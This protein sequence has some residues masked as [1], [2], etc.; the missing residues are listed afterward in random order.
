M[1][2][3]TIS[4]VARSYG[5][6]ARMIR[7]YEQVG[8]IN[9]L[10]NEENSYRVYDDAALKR[11]R[12]IILLRKLQIPV[13]N[14]TVILNNPKKT[15]KRVNLLLKDITRNGNDGIGKPICMMAYSRIKTESPTYFA[16]RIDDRRI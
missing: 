7:Y 2:L 6:S 5:I 3:Q 15:L 4:Q 9:S 16:Y 1:E 10:R 11:L 13:K 12:Q 8:L 14:I